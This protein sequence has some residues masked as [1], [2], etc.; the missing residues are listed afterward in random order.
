VRP[1][2][3]LWLL[4]LAL[5][6]CHWLLPLG[7]SAP[8]DGQIDDLPGDVRPSDLRHS[9]ATLTVGP[10]ALVAELSTPTTWETD[11]VLTGDGLTIYFSST[12]SSQYN[13]GCVFVATRNNPD[14]PFGTPLPILESTGSDFLTVTPDDLTAVYSSDR[15]MPGN[16]DMWIGTRADPLVPW[17]FAKFEPLA[18]LN[19]PNTEYD[20]RLS[21]NGLRLYYAPEGFGVATDQQLVVSERSAADKELQP[22]AGLLLG[23]HASQ[24]DA[25]PCPSQDELL[26]VFTS[27][28]DGGMGMT[29]L[30]YTVRPDPQSAFSSPRPLAEINTEFHDRDP[31]L[32][33]GRKWLYFTSTR[34]GN[35]N[36]YRAPVKL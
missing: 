19:T 20:A 36:I 4:P 29:D 1:S 2:P 5:A 26:L 17:D 12:R 9:D 23:S 18:K 21:A 16:V 8:P 28:R 35:Q 13:G 22:P 10:A 14:G 25:D 32:T 7:Q 3:G 24:V 6:G 27:T 30:W 31:F 15:L 33:T 34:D 11:P